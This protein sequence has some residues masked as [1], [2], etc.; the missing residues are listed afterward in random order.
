MSVVALEGVSKIYR[1]GRVSLTA[2]D[3]IDLRVAAGEFTC[4]AGPSGSGKSTL[5]HLAGMLDSPSR[6]TVSLLGRDCTGLGR[7]EAALLRRHHIGFVF[8]A[9]NL[10]PVLTAAENVEYVLLLQ[11][12]P[13][14]ERRQR[15]RAALEA[16][17]LSAWADHR[18]ADLSGGQQQRVAIARAIVGRPPFILADEP[19]G[20]LDSATGTA[21]I[22]LLL[23]IN[24]SQGTTFL[25]SS[26]DP[27]IIARAGRV[28][29]LVDGRI[30]GG[31]N[32]SHG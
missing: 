9:F 23:E 21:I 18:A 30:S 4:I 14:G 10:V 17:G 13:G 27:R 2:L 11:N 8:Q 32:R 29:R 25:F 7:R 6:G 5:L 24:R 22:D 15:V 28:I 16:V 31:D 3:R 1:S 20:S 12:R 26:H 19:T